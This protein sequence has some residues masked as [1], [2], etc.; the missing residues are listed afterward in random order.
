MLNT[1]LVFLG[2]GI[3]G[4]LRYWMTTFTYMIFDR[5]LPHGTIIVNVSGSLLM[6]LLTVLLE[7]KFSAF[8]THLRALLLVGVL[9]G[10][11]TFSTF[12]MDTLILFETGRFV[13]AITYIFG[14][15]LLC[16]VSVWGGALLAKH[17]LA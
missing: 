7:T 16:L 13:S 12:S 9:G 14:S 4:V 11:T 1:L 2:C 8:D 5:N 15:V 3:G 10:Y 17:I 6:G